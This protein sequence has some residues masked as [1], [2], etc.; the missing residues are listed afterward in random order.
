MCVCV[1]TVVSEKRAAS[2]C[3]FKAARRERT[4]RRLHLVVGVGVGVHFLTGHGAGTLNHVA[5]IITTDRQ[6]SPKMAVRIYRF[7]ALIDR[8]FDD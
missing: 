7:C 1:Y 6:S 2:D 4:S 8:H 3:R 5:V